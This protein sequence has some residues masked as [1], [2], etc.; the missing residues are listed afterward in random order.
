MLGRVVRDVKLGLS[1]TIGWSMSLGLGMRTIVYYPDSTRGSSSRAP[2]TWTIK[3]CWIEL[4]VIA[5]PASVSSFSWNNGGKYHMLAPKLEIF[6]TVKKIP[7]F[8]GNL[9]DLTL[10]GT[11]M[12]HGSI[13]TLLI[14]SRMV[15]TVVSKLILFV[16]H[17]I[18][19]CV[20]PTT[21]FPSNSS[22]DELV[23][24]IPG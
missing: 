15:V 22:R 16:A 17:F 18:N 10:A 4:W 20:F 23:Q 2:M 12:T 5:V 13:Q 24:L 8:V 19:I 6:S 7:K 14:G 11:V 3:W 9:K 21:M 1:N